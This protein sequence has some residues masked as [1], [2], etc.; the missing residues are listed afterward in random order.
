M[1]GNWDDMRNFFCA[2][3]RSKRSLNRA[4]ISRALNFRSHRRWMVHYLACRSELLRLNIFVAVLVFLCWLEHC[5]NFRIRQSMS[6][7]WLSNPALAIDHA[8]RALLHHDPFVRE[9]G[10]AILVYFGDTGSLGLIRN[11]FEHP[12][13][14]TRYRAQMAVRAIER[15]MPILF[16]WPT[17]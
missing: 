14:P 17:H 5:L 2:T 11:L 6:K 1:Q 9:D 4:E 13:L 12:D 16:V 7:A 10:L 15:E 3:W 8:R